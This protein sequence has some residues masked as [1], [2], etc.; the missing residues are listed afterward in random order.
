VL[1]KGFVESDLA[2]TYLAAAKKLPRIPVDEEAYYNPPQYGSV[3]TYARV[4]DIV[5][6]ASPDPPETLE[7][8]K[9]FDFGYGG[10][11]HLR[12]F[13]LMGAM[14]VG[15]DVDPKLSVLYRDPVEHITIV[16]GYFPADQRVADAVGGDYDLI[17]SKNT[18]KNGYIHPAQSVPERMRIDLGVSDEDFVATV[19]DRLKPQGLFVIYNICP[20]PAPP[21]K[22]YIPWADGNSPFTRAQLE[23]AGFEVLA[24]NHDDT[25]VVRSMAKLLGWD[26]DPADPM[27]IANDLFAMYTVARRR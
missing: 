26:K 18:L 22:P 15:V 1:L 27:D 20:A 8:Q 10:I 4:L 24:F 14:V 2:R 16:D 11:G 21:G 17:L 5:A 12:L 7:K 3:V 13:A 23:A 6:G 25:R 9:I 19:H